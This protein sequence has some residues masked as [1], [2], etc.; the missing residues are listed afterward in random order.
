MG[1]KALGFGDAVRLV[2]CVLL[3]EL[4]G[5]IGSAFT[6]SSI[7]TWYAGLNKPFFSPPNWVFGPVWIT[8]YAL[9]GVSL[10]IVWR[11]GLTEKRVK[12]AA[13]AFL[14][15]L[16]LNTSWSIAFFGLKSPLA[17]LLVIIPLW[18]AIALSIVRFRRISLSAA[19]LLIPYILWVSF[20]ML[21]NLSI[22]ALNP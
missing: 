12:D 13:A 4:A 6:L 11:M 10:Y 18:S 16:I 2:A 9:M 22:L 14:A 19:A 21:L 5:V 1:K 17:G 20:A 8:L 15:Q 3:C 7:P